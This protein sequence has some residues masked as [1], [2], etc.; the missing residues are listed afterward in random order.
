[1]K[2]GFLD[3]PLLCACVWSSVFTYWLYWSDIRGLQDRTPS[4]GLGIRYVATAFWCIWHARTSAVYRSGDVVSWN[5]HRPSYGRCRQRPV[6]GRLMS[7]AQRWICHR[8]V[9]ALKLIR[10]PRNTNSHWI[11]YLQLLCMDLRFSSYFIGFRGPVLVSFC[12]EN[13]WS[14][15]SLNVYFPNILIR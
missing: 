4:N 11:E 1:M 6:D 9:A 5:S 8:R 7:T 2:C 12:S 10:R 13:R 14:K 3:R 15:S